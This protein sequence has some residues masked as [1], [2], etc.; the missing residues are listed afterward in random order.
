VIALALLLVL[1]G[2]TPPAATV[3]VRMGVTVQPDTVTIG[4]HFA[5]RIRVR[6]PRGAVIGFPVGPDSG[7]TVEAVDPR[8]EEQSAD[9]TAV[10]RTAIYRLVAWSLGPQRIHL[11]DVVVS[12]AGADHRYAVP[13]A[14]LA[15][16]SVRPTD[17]TGKVPRPSR[18]VLV[19]PR[20][21][22]PWIV[23][24]LALITLLGWMLRRWLRR[25]TRARDR[26]TALA[27]AHRDFA[28][29]AALGLLDAGERGRYVALH[30]DVLRDY[31][32]AR[33]PEAARS[34]TTTELLA[35]LTPDAPVPL[36]RLSP[37]LLES[38][39]VKYAARPVTAGR[40]RE[41]G[42]EARAIVD[43]VEDAVVQRARA[44]AARPKRAA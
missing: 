44:A 3:P 2:A 7:L 37:V 30:V 20:A 23:G 40:A 43:A 9:T 14:M 25:S 26:S 22:W 33:I 12:A 10:E 4:E 31:L 35:A 24:A 28:R 6:A 8:R 29:I 18:D 16:R 17:S 1:Q 41:L 39:L 19:A 27:A 32:A 38:D 11:G 15:V 13:D 5:L 36:P 42:E 34:L 21:L